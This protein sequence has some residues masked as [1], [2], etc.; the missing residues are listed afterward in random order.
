[1]S[2]FFNNKYARYGLALFI[3]IAVT[4]VVYATPSI[5]GEVSGSV[6]D[7]LERPLTGATGITVGVAQALI[8]TTLGLIIAIV[9]LFAFNFFSHMQSKTMDEMERLGTRLVNHISRDQEG[10]VVLHEVA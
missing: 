2:L 3:F 5:A 6:K 8:A 10:R 9:S 1:M 4:V 7:A